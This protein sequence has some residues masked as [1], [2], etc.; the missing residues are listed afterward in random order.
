MH[1]AGA[2]VI[3][4]RNPVAGSSSLHAVYGIEMPFTR[5]AENR[6]IVPICGSYFLGTADE[7][8]NAHTK[9]QD[10]G[11][12]TAFKA[13]HNAMLLPSSTSLWRYC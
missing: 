2:S 6:E 3:Y 9:N 1:L 10:A 8:Q 5:D 12:F 11:K 4:T 13:L 7:V